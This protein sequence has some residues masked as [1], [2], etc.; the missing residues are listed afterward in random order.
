MRPWAAA[1]LLALDA[2]AACIAFCKASVLCFSASEVKARLAVAGD[3]AL[4]SRSAGAPADELSSSV[5]PAPN[6]MGAGRWAMTGRSEADFVS[7]SDSASAAA[8]GS[9]AC[10]TRAWMRRLTG[11]FAAGLVSTSFSRH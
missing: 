11:C 8:G 2:V 3:E 5:G 7:G 4:P 6:V 10:V 1:S 9:P